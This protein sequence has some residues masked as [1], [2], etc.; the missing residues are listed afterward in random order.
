MTDKDRF[1][2]LAACRRLW[3]QF[4]KWRTEAV[5]NADDDYEWPQSPG[6]I[7]GLILDN[8]LNVAKERGVR[9]KEIVDMLRG[10]AASEKRGEKYR[11]KDLH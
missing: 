1:L 2:D 4:E 9:S 5:E 8:L 10:F 11:I 7:L 3:E 6:G